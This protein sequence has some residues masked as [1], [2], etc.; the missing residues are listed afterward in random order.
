VV[1]KIT[2][3]GRFRRT[4]QAIQEWGMKHR[5]LPLKE[6]QRKLNEK[7]RGHEA[8]YGV[9]GNFRMLSRLRCEVA[10]LWRKWLLLRNRGESLNWERFQGKLRVFPLYPARIIHSSM[11]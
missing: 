11:Q 10:R 9:T 8:Y 7:L 4:L 5:H 1:Q 3:A 2:A 6:Q